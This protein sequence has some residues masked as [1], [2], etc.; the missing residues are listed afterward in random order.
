MNEE[1]RDIKGYE[2]K[3]QV[4]NLGR[5]KSLNYN[6][7]GVEGY[8]AAENS[9]GYLRVGLSKKGKRKMFSVHRLVAETFIPNPNNYS[10]VNHKDENKQ[11]NKVDNLEWCT[12][13]YNSNYGTHNKKISEKLKGKEKSKEHCK[14]LSLVNTKANSRSRKVKCI[15]TNK[16]FDYTEEAAK[17]YHIHATS[18]SACCRGKRKSAGKHPVTG[19]KLIWKYID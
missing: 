14:K 8:I 3:Y 12:P 13:K 18:I 1:W 6:K 5:V 7:T 16:I 15:T 2:G 4:S 9:R 19:E 17:F 10:Q 11:N